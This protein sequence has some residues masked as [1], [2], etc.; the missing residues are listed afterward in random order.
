MPRIWGRLSS[1][2]VRKVILAAQ[3]LGLPFARVEAGREFGVVGG[4]DVGEPI[5][6]GRRTDD[7]GHPARV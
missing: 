4:A 6:S 7:G 5:H 1:I 2:N 3:W